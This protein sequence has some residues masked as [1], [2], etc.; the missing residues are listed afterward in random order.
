MRRF[1]HT[2]LAIIRPTFLLSAFLACFACG[3]I[4]LGTP[5]NLA[6]SINFNETV[7]LDSFTFAFATD[8]ASSGQLYLATLSNGST[9]LTN[10]G[11]TG[12]GS[13]ATLHFVDDLLYVLHDGYSFSSSD[14]LQILDPFN[15]FDNIAQWSTGNGTNPNDVAISG[16]TAFISLY[17]PSADLN[18]IDE[19]GNFADVIAMDVNNGNITHRYS[20]AN[21][22]HQDASET[23]NASDLL[24]IGD[25][26]YVALQDLD[27]TF[28]PNE[29]GKI[30]IINI[31][32]QEIENV[33]T[34]Q[35]RNPTSLAV[36]H[37]GT[38]LFVS[39]MAGYNYDLQRFDITTSFG[40]IEVVNL[41]TLTTEL[42][43]SDES[44]SGYVE[45]IIASENYFYAI[46]SSDTNLEF[47]SKIVQLPQ[48]LTNADE[49]IVFYD[50]ET[51]IRAIT[52]QNGVLWV[53][54]QESG[55][56]SPEI[57]VIQE[58]SGDPLGSALFPMATVMSLTTDF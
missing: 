50:S 5:D 21:L 11:V 19:N 17:N 52:C 37:D 12:L 47:T 15:G 39:E 45:R 53:S 24:L 7:E 38:K 8:Y 36:N 49:A 54:S 41:A 27:E 22:L 30:G 42:F 16:S 43:L 6:D 28:S 26:L 29:N 18:N 51:D 23:A 31:R 13:S 34:L 9:K 10:T 44:F 40:G 32:T 33:V 4:T 46:V 57:L 25:R 14:N 35:G 2:F 56:S 3:E 48:N 1:F 55:N 58:T 20:F